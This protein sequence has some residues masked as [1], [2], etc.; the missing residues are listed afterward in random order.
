MKFKDLTGQRFGKLTV[1][2]KHGHNAKGNRITWECKC[3][4]GNTA[5]V[6]GIYLGRRTNSCGCMSSRATAS[7]R[8]STHHMSNT[9]IYRI[10][11]AMISRCTNPNVDMYYAYGAKGI[12][13]CDRW[14]KFENFYEDMGA[15]YSEGLSI[16][17]KDISADYCPENCIW[18]PK[19]KQAINKS[20][21]YQYTYN[22]ETVSL[23]TMC[24]IHNA[25]YQTMLNRIK[26]GM[27]FEEAL[28]TPIRKQKRVQTL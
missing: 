27:S 18:I 3:D 11:R 2:K 21:T 1:I 22:G 15:T 16:E 12:N 5:I 10:W 25:P 17:R 24:K 14:R 7:E 4:C 26:K 28:H 19:E 6:V 9:K 8:N 13:V 23:K 20:T